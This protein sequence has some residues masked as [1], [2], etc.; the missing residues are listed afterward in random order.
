MGAEARGSEVAGRRAIYTAQSP[1]TREGGTNQV[2]DTTRFLIM[3]REL[4][5]MTQLVRGAMGRAKRGLYHGKQVRSGNH[6]SFSNKKTKR[7]WKP[8]VQP[9]RLFSFELEKMFKLR[10]TT[11][12]LRCIDKAGGLDNYIMGLRGTSI[13]EGTK[14]HELK[15]LI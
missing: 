2:N 13:Q 11:H 10:V 5:Q 8:N 7:V 9:A 4:T 15:G 3:L 6:V 1:H 14:E 12:A